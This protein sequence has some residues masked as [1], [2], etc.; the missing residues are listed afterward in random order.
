MTCTWTT[1]IG[2]ASAST[3]EPRESKLPQATAFRKVCQLEVIARDVAGCSRCRWMLALGIASLPLGDART[4]RPVTA[5]A[6]AKE[7]RSTNVQDFGDQDE[8][9]THYGDHW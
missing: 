5:G 9:G 8:R 7:P 3:G 4:A 2:L 1:S 6:G